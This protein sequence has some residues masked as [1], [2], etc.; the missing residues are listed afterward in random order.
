MTVFRER[1]IKKVIEFKKVM[2][3]GPYSYRI[4]VLV[5]KGKDTRALILS[6]QE[7]RRK[8]L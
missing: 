8:S 7:H 6:W 2:W 3:V 4:G 5:G 1:S